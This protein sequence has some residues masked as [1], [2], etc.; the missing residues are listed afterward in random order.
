M[1]HRPS[2]P[3][4]ALANLWRL[5]AFSKPQP[6]AV[7]PEPKCF[8]QKLS[9]RGEKSWITVGVFWCISTFVRAAREA[10]FGA[11]FELWVCRKVDFLFFPRGTSSGRFSLPLFKSDN[12]IGVQILKRFLDAARPLHLCAVDFS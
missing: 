12:L 7:F 2:R 4:E 5:E 6:H 1:V 8:S 11:S 9:R 3:L 10:A